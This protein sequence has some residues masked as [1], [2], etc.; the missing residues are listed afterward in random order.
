MRKV[1]SKID[2]HQETIRLDTS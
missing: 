2:A 1:I